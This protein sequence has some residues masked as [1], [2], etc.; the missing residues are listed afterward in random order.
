LLH[1]NTKLKIY[2]TKNMPVIWYGCVTW[3]LTLREERILGVFGKRVLRRIFP[4]KKHEVIGEWR[5]LHNEELSDLYS[6]PNVFREIKSR[7]IKLM[8]HVARTGEKRGVYKVMVGKSEG[9]RL[10]GRPRRRCIFRT[11]DTR[12]WTR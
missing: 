7:R 8:E 10:L 5:Y 3:S 12:S 11:W 9:K 1:K 2:T 4:P 6:T